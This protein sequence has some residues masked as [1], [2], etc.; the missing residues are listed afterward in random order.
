[1]IRNWESQYRD[2]LL[3]LAGQ[4]YESAYMERRY[5]GR[6]LCLRAESRVEIQSGF[7]VI[8]HRACTG[9][10]Q[11]PVYRERIGASYGWRQDLNRLP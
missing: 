9:N 10:A 7:P 11:V 8:K 1:M 2:F 6:A 3:P 4:L 5:Q